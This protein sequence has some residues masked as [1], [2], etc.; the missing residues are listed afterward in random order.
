M[1]VQILDPALSL[2][3][4]FVLLSIITQPKKKSKDKSYFPYALLLR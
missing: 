2:F 1:L 4:L 3:T